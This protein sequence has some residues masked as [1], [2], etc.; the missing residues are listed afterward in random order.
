VNFLSDT[1]QA[2]IIEVTPEIARQLLDSSPGNR[3]MRPWYINQLAASMKAGHWL[4][5]NQ[6]I[7]ID[8]NGQLRDAHHRLTASVNHG[9]SFLSLIVWGLSPDSY[10]VVDR[11]LV[12]SYADILNL[13]APVAEPLRLGVGIATGNNRPSAPD[14]QPY[15]DA[16][17]QSAIETVV[18]YCPTARKTFS[19]APMKLAAAVTI[20]NGGDSN[21]VMN[22]YRAL[23]LC[24]FDSMS[25]ASKALTK[26]AQEGKVL[27]VGGNGSRDLIARALVVFD[28]DR[29]SVSKIQ[30]SD[31]SRESSVA[32][33]RSVLNNAVA[34]YFA[35]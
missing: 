5:T 20:M 3:R 13:P 6:G 29:Q 15:R 21:Y 27:S 26:Q 28:K 18:Q 14:M 25:Q 1:P 34:G 10:Q 9:V 23:V 35:S 24:D 32:L 7:G 4:V 17:L 2:A 12:R 8:S 30:I 31:A 16:G 11:G 22:Q 33:V 19:S